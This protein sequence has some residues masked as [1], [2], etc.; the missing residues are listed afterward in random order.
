MKKY[1]FSLLILFLISGCSSVSSELKTGRIN[2]KSV[3]IANIDDNPYFTIITDGNVSGSLTSFV[4]AKYVGKI[5]FGY[6]KRI[7][8]T[9][10][11]NQIKIDNQKFSF[12][13]DAVFLVSFK[14]KLKIKCINNS[15]KESLQ[16]LID[17]DQQVI[18]F[19]K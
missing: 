18:T 16:T 5:S 7:A 8:F 11:D 15:E 13:E 4:G 19:F 14:D 10:K 1:L 6:K 12:K 2:D 3:Y 9:A 17:S